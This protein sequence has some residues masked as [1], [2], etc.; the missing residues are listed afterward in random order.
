L[1]GAT[2]EPDAP[3]GELDARHGEPAGI[4]HAHALAV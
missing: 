3:P 4:T 2:G 1:T